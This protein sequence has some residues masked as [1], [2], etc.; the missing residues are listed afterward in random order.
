MCLSKGALSYGVEEI[1]DQRPY[2]VCILSWWSLLPL[3]RSPSNASRLQ[4]RRRTYSE[5]ADSAVVSIATTDTSPPEATWVQPFSRQN[6][7]DRGLDSVDVQAVPWSSPAPTN[8]FCTARS[9]WTGHNRSSPAV[10][11]TCSRTKN[12]SPIKTNATLCGFIFPL[13]FEI[14]K[15]ELHSARK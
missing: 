10:P 2:L 3:L 5:S 6:R 9:S 8:M 15:T 7:I 14:P 1:D 4:N 11:K 12:S 13:F